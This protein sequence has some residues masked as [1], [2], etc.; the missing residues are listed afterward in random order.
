MLPIPDCCPGQLEPGHSTNCTRCKAAL[1]GS[2]TGKVNHLM[3]FPPPNKDAAYGKLFQENRQHISISGVQE[4]YSLGLVKNKLELVERNGHF[5]LKPIPGNLL[6][7]EFIPANEH[8]TMQL[9]KQVFGIET[10]VNALIFFND[11][12]PAYLTKRFDYKPDGTKYQVE[13]FATLLGKT[14]EMEGPNFKYNASYEDI[15]HTI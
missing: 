7:R 15:G 6:N 5:I 1:F 4:K 13:D 10:A 14:E 3:P 11:G 8:L 9:A 12:T 2:R